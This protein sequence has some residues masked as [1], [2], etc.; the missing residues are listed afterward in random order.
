M[1]CYFDF[2]ACLAALINLIDTKA[3]CRHLK[4]LSCGWCYQS[5]CTRDTVSHVGIFSTHL[6][7]LL[8]LFGSSLPPPPPF[9]A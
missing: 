3:K 1:F 9:P 2:R 4:K 5:L 6:C 7:E 8:P